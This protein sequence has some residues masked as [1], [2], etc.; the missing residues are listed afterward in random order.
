MKKIV[1]LAM[2]CIL[3]LGLCGCSSEPSLVGTTPVDNGAS[4]EA[5]TTENNKTFKLGD[6][7]ELYDVAVS[8][9]NLVESNGSQYNK[10]EE[11]KIFVLCEFEIANNSKE[12][13][14]VSSM[15]SFEAYCDDYS[16]DYS[17]G[18]LLE[19]GNMEQLDGTVAPGK[20][21]KGAIGY[22]LPTDWKELEIHY[23]PGLLN[24][25]EIVFIATNSN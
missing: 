23:T 15:L 18:A 13:I 7:V 19:A 17:F 9:T 25:G 16:C 22:E 2:T 20:K 8:F 1:S 12:D 3:L 10:P 5:L 24:S 4:T 14:A 21:M 11:G 6:V